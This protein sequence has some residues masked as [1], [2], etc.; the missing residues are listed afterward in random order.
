MTWDLNIANYN[1]DEIHD[2][3][4]LTRNTSEN[5]KLEA[6]SSAFHKVSLDTNKTEIDKSR[7]NAF[8]LDAGEMIGLSKGTL[9]AALYKRGFSEIKEDAFNK[10]NYLEEVGSHMIITHPR[11]VDAYTERKEGR[12]TS[13]ARNPPGIINPI[14]VHTLNKAINID[15]RFRDNYYNTQ[16]GQFSVTLPT[17]ITNCV[18]MR[19]G[20]VAI[21]LT[22]YTFNAKLG[23]TTFVVTLN[24]TF[25][26]PYVV[27][28]PDGNYN[29][30]F[31][32]VTGAQN[33]EN[34][35]NQ[36]LIAAGIDINTQLCYR[37]DRATGKS[38]FA[39]PAPSGGSGGIN[40]FTIQFNCDSEGKTIP[41]DNIQLRLGWILGFRVGSY[42][43]GP[44]SA[45]T[46]A[47]VVSEGIC[48][49]KGPRY[50]FL[51]VD[52]YT[53]NVNDY[54]YSA[55]QS[56]LLP[57]NILT[58][59]DIGIIEDQNGFFQLA[60][61]ESFTTQVN[62]SRSYFG[63]ITIEKLKL[64]LYDEYGRVLDLNNMDW[65][66]TLAFDCLYQ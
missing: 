11:E 19:L 21:P 46:G 40:T 30:P 55:S 6:L 51:A 62:T 35:V 60:D 41:D 7:F 61:G 3:F 64:T 27:T 63:P 39:V 2:L 26:F 23:N 33:I 66:I 22:F 10:K 52:E 42:I 20:N 1:R 34:V 29:T 12:E 25:G 54:F 57:N 43:G 18:Q 37:I 38:A 28:I 44:S 56:S 48:L 31:R 49:T 47:A 16:S 13:E 53:N 24:D 58:R 14:K 36:S 17:R 4:G 45:G 15:S 9:Q 59:I 32:N 65:S 50:I 5:S 8:L